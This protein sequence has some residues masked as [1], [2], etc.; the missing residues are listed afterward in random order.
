MDAKADQTSLDTLTTEVGTKANQED[1]NAALSSKADQNAL[2]N[3]TNAVGN[4]ADQTAL[5]ALTTEVGTKATKA[6]L[7]AFNVM[8]VGMEEVLRSMRGALKVK[9]IL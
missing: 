6:E 2:D 8:S 3:L 5:D 1:V 7:D 9:T 4:K